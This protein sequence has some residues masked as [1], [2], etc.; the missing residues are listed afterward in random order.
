MPNPLTSLQTRTRD[1]LAGAKA[2]FQ[3]WPVG[4]VFYSLMVVGPAVTEEL[5][6]RGLMLGFFLRVSKGN[7]GRGV[8]GGIYK[9]CKALCKILHQEVT[10]P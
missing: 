5:T 9:P 6:F 8:G 10:G 2:W 1:N 4:L 7:G 3:P